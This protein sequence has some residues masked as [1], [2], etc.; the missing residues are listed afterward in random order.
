MLNN[1]NDKVNIVVKLIYM[2]IVPYKTSK[3][4]KVCTVVGE[5]NFWYV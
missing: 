4:S 5:L 1:T 2:Q 3:L